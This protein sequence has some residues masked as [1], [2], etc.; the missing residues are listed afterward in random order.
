MGELLL[1]NHQLHHLSQSAAF[2]LTQAE[3]HKWLMNFHAVD[4]SL[5]NWGSEENRSMRERRGKCHTN[6]YQLNYRAIKS[7]LES[8]SF[9]IVVVLVR[10]F[11]FLSSHND[12]MNCCIEGA[13]NNTDGGNNVQKICDQFSLDKE[14]RSAKKGGN[15]SVIYEFN[16]LCLAESQFI[17][18]GTFVIFV[19]TS[20][21]AAAHDS[22][23]S[24]ASSAN[25]PLFIFHVRCLKHKVFSAMN[26]MNSS[27]FSDIPMTNN[28]SEIICIC[29]IHAC[30]ENQLNER[31]STAEANFLL[32]I[33]RHKKSR[34]CCCWLKCAMCDKMKHEG[35]TEKIVQCSSGSQKWTSDAEKSRWKTKCGVATCWN[36]NHVDPTCAQS[37]FCLKTWWRVEWELQQRT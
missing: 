10:K 29:Y 26:Q 1:C 36:W 6:E 19:C 9:R 25:F 30:E 7:T 2:D 16:K 11:N 34:R 22:F 15:S 17:L 8:V 23:G 21:H 32:L 3:S 27:D 13:T 28:N 18:A 35:H 4:S 5:V 33:F 12:D 37:V 14:K 20:K 24:R 31:G